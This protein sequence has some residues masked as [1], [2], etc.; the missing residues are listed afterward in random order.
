MAYSSGEFH[1][2]A[3]GLSAIPDFKSS[4]AQQREESPGYHSLDCCSTKKKQ[5]VYKISKAS[6]TQT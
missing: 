5:I 4:A 6:L 1:C 2:G 3:C